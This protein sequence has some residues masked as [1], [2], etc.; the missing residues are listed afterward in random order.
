MLRYS[1]IGLLGLFAFTPTP[2][3]AQRPPIVT[4]VRHANTVKDVPSLDWVG[5]YDQLEPYA[6]W[7]KETATCAAVPLNGAR[8]DSVQFYYINAADFLPTPT[9]KPNRM[10]AAVTYAAREQIFLSVLHLRNE[11]VVKHEM[12]HQILYWWGESDWD[13]DARTEFKKCGLQVVL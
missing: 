2:S 8:V 12:M 10:V 6:R 3:G 11:V 1:A 7:W 9:D 13:N 5:L 4:S